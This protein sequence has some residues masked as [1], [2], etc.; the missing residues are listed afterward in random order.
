MH[1]DYIAPDDFDEEAYDNSI[2]NRIKQGWIVL[3]CSM[4]TLFMIRGLYFYTRP[5]VRK[6]WCKTKSLLCFQSVIIFYLGIN[7]FTHRHIS[8]LFIILLFTQYS[9]FITF[10]I[11]IDSMITKKQDE[12]R[13]KSKQRCFNYIFR[14]CMHGASLGLFI[15]TFFMK[16]CHEAIY[17]VNFITL[18]IIIWIHQFYDIYLA[19]HDYM[20]DYENLPPMSWNKL[21]F[22]TELFKA[23]TKFLFYGNLFFGLLSMFT[24][25]S[26]YFIINRQHMEGT[27]QHLLCLHGYEWIYLSPVGNVFGTLHQL[28]VLMQ[29]NITQFVLVRLPDRMEIFKH[30][31]VNDLKSQMRQN[32]IDQAEKETEKGDETTPGEDAPKKSINPLAAT[33]MKLKEAQKKDDDAFRA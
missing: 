5:H 27:N 17:P 32:L 1:P 21:K 22:N 29:I 6:G 11:V 2:G 4:M 15:S 24:V 8:G 14:W 9:L 23:Q 20:V 3:Q 31:V 10:C 18:V 16:D 33:L 30:D 25:A 19:C 13:L 7:E 26:G 12:T 28:L